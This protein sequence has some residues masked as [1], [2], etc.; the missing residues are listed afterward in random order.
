VKAKLFR[1]LFEHRS[2]RSYEITPKAVSPRQLRAR[3]HLGYRQ[4][5]QFMARASLIEAEV[6]SR[7][8]APGVLFDALDHCDTVVDFESRCAGQDGSTIWIS[9]NARVGAR[10][11]G[12]S[13]YFPA[14]CPPITGPHSAGVGSARLEERYR[15][16]SNT[17]RCILDTIT[18]I[19]RLA[20]ALKEQGVTDLARYFDL[21]IDELAAGCKRVRRGERRDRPAC[22]GA[23]PMNM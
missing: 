7:R 3:A 10:P 17:R 4:P 23:R 13:D 1:T 14:S 15:C 20:G 8:A 21:I 2:R 12:P 18:A 16:S 9:E 5:G 6:D 11:G 22:F 19:R